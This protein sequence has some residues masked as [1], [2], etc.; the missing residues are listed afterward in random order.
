MA[1]IILA[2]DEPGVLDSIQG[3]LE[4]AHHRVRTAMHGGE[5]FELV[6]QQVPDI[7]ITDI[8]M[9]GVEGIETIVRLRRAHPDLKILAIS[10]GGQFGRVGYLDAASDLGANGVLAKPFSM[11]KLFDSLAELGIDSAIPTTWA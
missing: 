10:G 9:P 11:N 5:V 3:C 1:D 8:I 4:S 2:D 7:V 6:Q